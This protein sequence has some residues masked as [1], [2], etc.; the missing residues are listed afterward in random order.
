MTVVEL[1]P[2]L[3]V[4]LHTEAERR[5][6]NVE[7][8]VNDWLEEHLWEERRRKIQDES[9][10]FQA[11]HRELFQ[12]YAGKYVAM[13]DGEVLDSDVDIVVLYDR[14]HSKYGDDPILISPVT[15]DPIQ[16]FQVLSPQLNNL[17]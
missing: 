2:K 9:Q 8:L 13:C 6:T 7:A 17:S 11:M 10:R 15:D 5:Q 1:R 16:T 14:I 4:L 12:K 3:E